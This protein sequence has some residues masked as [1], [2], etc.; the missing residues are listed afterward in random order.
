MCVSCMTSMANTNVDTT[1]QVKP[2]GVS[3][4]NKGC[5]F[6]QCLAGAKGHKIAKHDVVSD[7]NGVCDKKHSSG[8][9]HNWET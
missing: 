7:C 1:L 6:P 5:N 3:K 4:H 2:E 9:E 8:E